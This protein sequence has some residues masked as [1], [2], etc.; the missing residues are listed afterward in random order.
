V[1]EKQREYRSF[2]MRYPYSLYCYRIGTYPE[3][4]FK[5]MQIQEIGGKKEGKWID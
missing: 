1:Q 2:E 4:L 3:M 5:T